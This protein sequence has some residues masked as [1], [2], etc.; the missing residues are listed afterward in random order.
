MPQIVRAT[1]KANLFFFV[2]Q[3]TPNAA[4]ITRQGMEL[5]LLLRDVGLLGS[6]SGI[7]SKRCRRTEIVFV[8][9]PSW[10]KGWKSPWK[11]KLKGV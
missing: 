5:V 4:F 3:K 6:S 1:I 8:K 7:T 2:N 11:G 9:V 10:L